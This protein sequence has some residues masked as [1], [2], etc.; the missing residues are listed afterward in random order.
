M[1][2]AFNPKTRD[3]LPPDQVQ[4][5]REM[6]IVDGFIS[7]PLCPYKGVISFSKYI[8]FTLG[9]DDFAGYAPDAVLYGKCPD[10]GVVHRY[11]EDDEYLDDVC[12]P[13]WMVEDGYIALAASRHRLTPNRAENDAKKT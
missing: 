13:E 10:T 8:D 9:T 7:L 1:C 11:V 2:D 3:V 4:L 6:S 12:N 5:N